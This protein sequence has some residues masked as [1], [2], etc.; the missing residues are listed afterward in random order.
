MSRYVCVPVDSWSVLLTNGPFG[1]DVGVLPS[2]AARELGCRAVRAVRVDDDEMAY[3]SP[4][5]R[6][7]R[8]LD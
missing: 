3:P 4:S 2:Y 5:H 8:L 7:G 1:T 6:T